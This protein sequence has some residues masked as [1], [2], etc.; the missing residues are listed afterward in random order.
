M[1]DTA[2]L[3]DNS[4]LLLSDLQ[5]LAL[6]SGGVDHRQELVHASGLPE[7][8]VY[9]RVDVLLDR[10]RYQDGKVVGPGT[11]QPLLVSRDHPHQPGKQLAVTPAG[12]ELLKTVSILTA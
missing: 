7:R 12:L 8:T 1:T 2:V 3:T 6:V 9:R 11:G 5:L 4:H 10:A